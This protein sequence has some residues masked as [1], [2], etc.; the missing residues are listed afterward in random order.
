MIFLSISVIR[1]SCNICSHVSRSKDAL[2]KH[3]SYRHSGA[4]SSLEIETRRKR[5]P[6]SF[7]QIPVASM[8]KDYLSL[9]SKDSITHSG[10]SFIRTNNSSNRNSCTLIGSG[11]AENNYTIDDSLNSPEKQLT[12]AAQ[13]NIT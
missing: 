11:A 3:V 6:K 7:S 9:N 2:R 4:S 12:A 8:Q 13:I 10:Y 1:Y 5:T